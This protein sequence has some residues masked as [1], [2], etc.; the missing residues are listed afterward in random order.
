MK[1]LQ[2]AV[3]QAKALNRQW[4]LVICVFVYLFADTSGV[5]FDTRYQ[6][7]MSQ[8]GTTERMKEK[9]RRAQC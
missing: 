6:M 2:A 4:R 5:V 8:G 3:E 7:V 9:V 1:Y